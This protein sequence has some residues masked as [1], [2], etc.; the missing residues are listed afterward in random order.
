M[1]SVGS[2]IL[3]IGRSSTATT[4]GPL[5]TTAFIVSLAIAFQVPTL[6]FGFLG[7]RKCI[8]L[9]IEYDSHFTAKVR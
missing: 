3:G 7:I 6:Q 8:S 9:R 2:L 1:I 4:W 5:K